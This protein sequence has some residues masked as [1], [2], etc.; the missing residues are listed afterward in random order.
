[1]EPDE[2]Y[3]YPGTYYVCGKCTSSL[4]PY[5][6]EDR[7]YRPRICCFNHSCPMFLVVLELGHE[8]RVTAY[9]TGERALDPRLLQAQAT[10]A[11]VQ[12]GTNLAYDAINRT[13][14]IRT[15]VDNPPRLDLTTI[16]NI[17]NPGREGA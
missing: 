14:T 12:A 8:A 3:V 6:P 13:I 10:N 17:L 7:P 15:P 4:S 11:V 1:M 16:D 5:K 9:D 2:F